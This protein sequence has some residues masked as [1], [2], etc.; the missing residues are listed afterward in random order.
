MPQ[1]IP[2][3]NTV[4][5]KSPF[6]TK[7]ENISLAQDPVTAQLCGSNT[8]NSKHC[9]LRNEKRD[10]KKMTPVGGT[11][12]ITS[13]LDARLGAKARP[14]R[15]AH[16]SDEIAGIRRRGIIERCFLECP[17]KAPTGQSNKTGKCPLMTHSGQFTFRDH[18]DD[19]VE[20]RFESQRPFR[21]CC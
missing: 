2:C 4:T 7:T 10:K 13:W 5:V 1:S 12:G 14:D 6:Q 21:H 17:L 11:A 16:Q 9:N 3:S 15:H 20:S 18:P 19:Q 8:N